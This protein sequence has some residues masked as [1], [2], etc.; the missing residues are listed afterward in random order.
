MSIRDLLVKTAF[1]VAL[2]T[3]SRPSD[4]TRIDITSI[5]KSDSSFSFDCVDPKEFK[6]A[7][8]HSAS[9]SKQRSKR[10]YIGS[11]STAPRLCPFSA[12]RNVRTHYTM[13]R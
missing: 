1:L 7:L 8:S 9:T 2:V 12:V 6:I 11:Y 5:H 13:E 4:L 3:A 10:M